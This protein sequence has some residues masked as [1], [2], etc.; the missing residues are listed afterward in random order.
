MEADSAKV[1]GLSAVDCRTGLPWSGTGELFG[2][3]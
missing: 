1:A 3:D 2:T